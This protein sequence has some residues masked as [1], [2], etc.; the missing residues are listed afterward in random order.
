MERKSFVMK[1]E[2]TMPP[3]FV[4]AIAAAVAEKL[5]PMLKGLTSPPTK[6]DDLMS[7]EELAAH[8]GGVSKDWIYQRTAKNEIPFMKVGRLVKFR[9]SDIDRWLSGRSVPAAAPLSAPL[10]GKRARD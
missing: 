2:L 8:L 9:R 6:A 5:R 1:A 7:M 3:E 4:D 10:P